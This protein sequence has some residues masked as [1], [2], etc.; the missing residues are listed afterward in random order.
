MN[1]KLL[2][3][4]KKQNFAEVLNFPKVIIL[5]FKTKLLAHLRVLGGLYG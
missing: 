1:T 2:N 5:Y 3:N 4:M